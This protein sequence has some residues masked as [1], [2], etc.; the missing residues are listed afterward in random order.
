MIGHEQILL[1]INRRELATILAALRFHQDE[2]LQGGKTIPD[3]IIADIATDGGTLAALDCG[4]VNQ[5]CQKLNLDWQVTG[6][7][8]LYTQQKG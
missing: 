5:L 3:E 4:E 8:I 1:P 6:V 2:N 7:N